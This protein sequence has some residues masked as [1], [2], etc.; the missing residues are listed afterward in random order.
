M[1]RS[2][3]SAKSGLTGKTVR[4][5]SALIGVI[6]AIPHGDTL[7]Q[8]SRRTG[9]DGYSISQRNEYTAGSVYLDDHIISQLL[10]LVIEKQQY[11]VWSGISSV[12]S[13][14][15]PLPLP[16]LSIPPEN[17]S[18]SKPVVHV[19]ARSFETRV[20]NVTF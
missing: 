20:L 18:K 6:V 13:L 8:I 9:M 19:V 11:D 17:V 7:Y 10:Q 14:S 2:K 16:P 4:L 5:S 15:L 3:S 12:S 1:A